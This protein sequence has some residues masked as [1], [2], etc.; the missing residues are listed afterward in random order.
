MFAIGIQ[1]SGYQEIL[2]VPE[3]INGTVENHQKSQKYP[4]SNSSAYLSTAGC[5]LAGVNPAS[6][7]S[8]KSQHQDIAS[9]AYLYDTPQRLSSNFQTQ[10]LLRCTQGYMGPK[11]HITPSLRLNIRNINN[12]NCDCTSFKQSQGTH[13]F[14]LAHRATYHDQRCLNSHH[15][16]RLLFF[17]WNC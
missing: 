5:C 15:T 4:A 7:H 10:A 2:D 3:I 13:S 9:K 6:F 16:N 17:L 8:I 11:L 1:L 14:R 12:Y